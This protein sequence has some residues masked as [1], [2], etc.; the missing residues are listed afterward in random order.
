MKTR[1][2]TKI[3]YIADDGKEFTSKETCLAYE[4]IESIKNSP[5]NLDSRKIYISYP[6]GMK[7]EQVELCS[8]K[9]KAQESIEG[10]IGYYIEEIIID[11]R[12]IVDEVIKRNNK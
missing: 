9:K 12:G 11:A 2:E 6:R 7:I 10:T 5:I 8:T 1:T 3:I 4:E